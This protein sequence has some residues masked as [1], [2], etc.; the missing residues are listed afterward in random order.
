MK[1]FSSGRKI[2]LLALA[3][4]TIAYQSNAVNNPIPK[5]AVRCDAGSLTISVGG[6]QNGYVTVWATDPAGQNVITGA[7]DTLLTVSGL[8]QTTTL[9]AAFDSSGTR[10]QFVPVVAEIKVFKDFSSG[11]SDV[12]A[13]LITRFNFQNNTSDISGVIPPNNGNPV[14]ITYGTDRF[15]RPESAAVFNGSTSVVT[16]TTSFV[17]PL[18]YSV[19]AW[20]RTP[21]GHDRG[22]RI[23]GFGNA[24]T[25]TN[26]GNY[27]RHI[28]L[29]D[30]GGLTFG[31]FTGASNTINT[32]AGEAYN[33][34]EWHHVVATQSN[35]AGMA[36]YVDGR[37]VGTLP[38][39]T[40]QDYTGWWKIGNDRVW[41]GA[42]QGA[43]NGSI[44]DVSIYNRQIS[45]EEV[46][47]LYSPGMLVNK[48]VGQSCGQSVPAV[49]NILN[50][51]RGYY[52]QLVDASTLQPASE[53][54][55]AITFGAQLTTTNPITQTSTFK[56]RVID[57]VSLCSRVFDEEI[58]IPFGPAA[59]NPTVDIPLVCGFSTAVLTASSPD[60]VEYR[61]W[62]SL[63]AETPVLVGNSFTT[64]TLSPGDSAV[65]WVSAIASTGC[66]S[67]RVRAVVYS[68]YGITGNT[69][70]V[71]QNL[72]IT[73]GD[74]G[75]FND[76]SGV[77]PAVNGVATSVSIGNGRYGTA[78]SAWVFNGTDS[79]VHTT[80]NFNNPTNF[81]GSVWIN[82]T[83]NTGGLIVGLG[84]ANTPDLSTLYDRQIYMGNDG[85]VYFGVIGGGERKAISSLN[86][87]NDGKWHH[88]AYFYGG[89]VVR[90]WIDG[91]LNE[92]NLA[93]GTG[94]NFNPARWQFGRDLLSGNM[95]EPTS[96][97]WAGSMQGFRYYTRQL[98]INEIK[99]LANQSGQATLS[100]KNQCGSNTGN[101][102]IVLYNSTQGVIYNI[103]V[104]N[105]EVGSPQNGNG[106]TLFFNQMLQRGINNLTVKATDPQ[107][108]CVLVL[109][110]TFSFV[111]DTIP[112]QPVVMNQEVCGPSTFTISPSGA[113]RLRW[114]TSEMGGSPFSTE[115]SIITALVN[116][117]DS[118]VYFVS[119][120]SEFGCESQR[121][122]VTVKSNKIPNDLT[123]AG[124]SVVLNGLTLHY[125]L[126]GN[127]V[128]GSGIVP[129]NNGTFFGGAPT[130]T[131]DRNGRANQAVTLNGTNQYI[132]TSTAQTAPNVFSAGIWFKTNSTTGG[133]IFGFG[134]AQSGNSSSYDRHLVMLNDGRVYFGTFAG[135][136]N[137]RTVTSTRAYN[138]DQWHYA[139]A[140]V[141]AAQFMELIID[142]VLIGRFTTQP[143]MTT[144]VNGFWRIGQDN[145]NSWTT[146]TSTFFR[147]DVDDFVVYDR[148]ISN[149]EISYNIL[150]KAISWADPSP[151]ATEVIPTLRISNPE[152][153][154]TYQLLQ[155]GSQVGEVTA[156]GENVVLLVGP[157]I[158]QNTSYTVRAVNQTTGCSFLSDSVFTITLR[159]PAP[160]VTAENVNSCGV[161]IAGILAS[162]T[163]NG[164]YRWY[165]EPSGGSALPN[166]DSL[167]V[168]PLIQVGD[169]LVYFVAA[170]N[171]FGCESSR[172]RVVARALRQPK[173]NG[174][175]NIP[176]QGLITWYK[177]DSTAAD[178]SGVTPPN[179]GTA[180]NLVA[181]PDRL[182]NPFGAYEF[183]G[184]NSSITT[185]TR[186]NNPRVFTASIRFKTSGSTGGV[187]YGFSSG[188][189]T[190]GG[191]HDRKVY[192]T[193]DGRIFAG[194]Y[195]GARREINSTASYNDGQWHH[196]SFAVGT[197][198]ME[199]YV[200]GILVAQNTVASGP[201]NINGWWMIGWQQAWTGNPRF[202]GTLD[203]FTL[204]NRALT[205]EEVLKLNGREGVEYSSGPKLFCGTTGTSEIRL[206]KTEPFVRY[207][208]T[209]NGAPVGPAL[210]GSSDTITLPTGQVSSTTTFK[211]LATDTLTGCT[212]ELDSALTVVVST[213]PMQPTVM[214]SS[215]CATGIVGLNASGAAQG[216]G[217]R[218]YTTPTGGSPVV[219]SNAVFSG[220]R[221]LVNIP[222]NATT[223]LDSAERW[224]SIVNEAGCESPRVRIVGR[225]SVLPT[226]SITPSTA[227]QTVCEGDSITLSAPEGF[228]AY[229]WTTGQTTREIRVGAATSGIR[230]TVT[231]AL[232]CISAP[233]NA[234]NVTVSPKP[235]QP[236]LQTSTS[237][238][239]VC[240]MVARFNPLTPAT[241]APQFRWFLNGVL[242]TSLITATV[243]NPANG[244]WTVRLFRNGC[245]SDSANALV[246]TEE[247]RCPLGISPVTI[248]STNWE[249]Y[250][251]PNNGRFKI[252]LGEGITENSSSILELTDVL[253]K[254]WLI[255]LN[256]QSQE[257]DEFEVDSEQIPAGIYLT[258]IVG[259]TTYSTKKLI[260]NK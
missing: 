35:T 109:D 112:T 149:E 88:I 204:F 54:V 212:L 135:G 4:F 160:I 18:N 136:N 157:S 127:L 65:V 57:S 207:Q 164:N 24:Q 179:T 208:L 247:N 200:D 156:S 99:E 235:N 7:N 75:G 108:G 148:I 84:D 29:R 197:E 125:A 181:V 48:Q 180:N 51:E 37:L 52:Y 228:A 239:G 22:G 173:N 33:D 41:T 139:V 82:T 161:G 248:A 224:V 13:G 256:A 110:S 138:D 131:T 159:T 141:D 152:N 8:T 245:L 129:P 39:L 226:A 257:G 177:M 166:Q 198:N 254:V 246:V 115:P 42:S 150:G 21:V 244:T 151:C 171:E 120:V 172:V 196:V 237:G 220:S 187:L 143:I 44:D 222:V 194:I 104:N 9:Y 62:T 105:A 20:F 15:G 94:F 191:Q 71:N 192:M 211:V 132:S 17:R 66:E 106:D 19:S 174:F 73:Y 86:P 221:L 182:G 63:N 60:A 183:N 188:Q 114:Y 1:L 61:W 130:Y 249:V 238:T 38:I 11:A 126:N 233:S 203:D 6:L 170:V 26:S 87:L 67:E 90:L 145:L 85:K 186:Y 250:P 70:V 96:N 223:P 93:I 140:R 116:Q 229:L 97:A 240:S 169:S 201:Q 236:W 121:V 107:S 92:E 199:L 81:T 32:P 253:G 69:I 206:V 89:G 49:V 142:G 216:Q 234:V 217:Y 25:G 122:R 102:Q 252:K 23:V 215:R 162:G 213:I 28:F 91:E 184:T 3:A 185:T 214:D 259:G 190:P 144:N 232:G 103:L 101:A 56:V 100:L 195:T 155:S 117:N 251:N 12:T 189:N 202:T 231:N 72:R 153:G 225:A 31:V 58:L 230:V 36:F 83:T 34:G 50:A 2:F 137:R 16:T 255:K 147:G 242:Q 146:P 168:T 68:N 176:T 43:F 40:A 78:N 163:T 118:L 79:K 133:K 119:S 77:A 243:N 27:D 241:P 55:R 210:L 165:T 53:L 218:W 219:I 158:S 124:N 74:N 209:Q 227:T 260:I 10:S 14:A 95:N 59:T 98:N 30:N 5:N 45:A 205:A 128:D 178:A 46:Q 80:V 123:T 64:T 47:L 154:V 193:T 258:R 175:T 111:I 134:N 167:L 76:L 113:E